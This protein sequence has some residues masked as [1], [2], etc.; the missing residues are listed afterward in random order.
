MPRMTR[1]LPWF[2]TLTLL[3]CSEAAPPAAAPEPPSV[4][5]TSAPEPAPEVEAAPETEPQGPPLPAAAPVEIPED[6]QKVIAAEDRDPKDRELDAGRHPGELLAFFGIAPGMKV[7][8]LGAGT[9]YTAELLARRVGSKGKVFA[10]NPK[11]VLEKFAE[12]PWSERLKKPVMKPVVRVDRE[13][14]DP[15]PKEAKN[16]DAVFL[17]LFYHDTY[18]MET[19][20]AKMNAAIFKALKPGGT[21]AV[22]DHSAAAGRGAGDVK[23]LH[24]IEEKLVKEEIEAAGFELEAEGQFL[25]NPKDTLDWNDAPSASADKRGTSDRFVL[26]F[27]KPKG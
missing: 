20:R 9:G 26:K 14:D 19:D 1:S 25:R 6:I 3:A 18:W 8:E 10:Q 21:Y 23:T 4:A 17:V 7:A 5:D 27:K 12:E 16:L 2:A 22:I 13:F 11:F 15:L 24:R